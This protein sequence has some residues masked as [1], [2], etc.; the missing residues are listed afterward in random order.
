MKYTIGKH[1]T[2]DPITAQCYQLQVEYEEGREVGII[3]DNG[4]VCR[5]LLPKVTPFWLVLHLFCEG[6]SIDKA[7]DC[8]KKTM[9]YGSDIVVATWRHLLN[10]SCVS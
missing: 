7:C 4:L 5:C 10:S 2:F 8:V 9:G 6:Y 1:Y 3:G